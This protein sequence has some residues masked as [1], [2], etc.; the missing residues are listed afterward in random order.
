MSTNVAAGV[1][2]GIAAAP[3]ASSASVAT[4]FTY[5]EWGPVLA[6]AFGAAAV[7]LVLLTF[8]T[9]IGLTAVSPWPNAG[10]SLTASLI[11]AAVWMAIVQVGSFAAG[12]YI[13]GR[14]RTPWVDGDVPERQFRD[15]A[16][17]FIVWALAVVVMGAVISYTTLQG[18]KTTAQAGS[19]AAAAGAA[20][21]ASA[22]DGGGDTLNPSD[23]AVDYLLRRDAP[24]AGNNAPVASSDV[25][26]E[27]V[28]IVTSS[29]K[30]GSLAQRDKT[31]LAQVVSARTGLPAADAERRVDTAFADAKAADTKVREAADKARKASAVAAF[32][33]AA[34]LLVGGVAAAAGASLGGRH[35]DERTAVRFFGRERF[36]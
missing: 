21:L 33:T 13:A 10:L 4:P 6:G 36:W 26:G 28:R 3:A 19:T 20:G 18:A 9:G 34:T 29:L 5:V 11:I 16:H 30:D 12:G 8:G 7:S 2:R 27:L 25:R 35:R 15:G 32:L 22:R 14:T 24:G 23:V 31:Y 17:G 1:T